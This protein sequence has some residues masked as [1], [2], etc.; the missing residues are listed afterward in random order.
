MTA[1]FSPR[2]KKEKKNKGKVEDERGCL[3]A[4]QADLA[5]ME[6]A[7]DAQGSDKQLKSPLVCSQLEPRG[8]K[9]EQ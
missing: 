4:I 5:G 9:P 7:S 1:V 8:E 3:A 6:M 2:L